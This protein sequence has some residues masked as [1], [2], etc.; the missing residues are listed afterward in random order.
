[1][2][3]TIALRALAALGFPPRRSTTRSTR[4]R[5]P[6]CLETPVL[7]VLKLETFARSHHSGPAQFHDHQSPSPTRPGLCPMPALS[8]R[9]SS[10]TTTMSTVTPGSGCTP[11]LRC[12]TAPQPRAAPSGST[13]STQPTLLTPSGSATADPRHRSCP[14]PPG[15]AGPHRGPL[16]H[17]IRRGDEFSSR[18]KSIPENARRS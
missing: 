2:T 17:P 11:R 9:R 3:R 7:D 6:G 14:R 10:A 1:M 15:S 13:P 12:T 8:A 16:I 18:R 4:R 5:C